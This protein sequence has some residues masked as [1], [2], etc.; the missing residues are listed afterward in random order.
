[1]A[2][3]AKLA[4]FIN[5]EFYLTGAFGEQRQTH[6]HKGVDLSTGEKSPIYSLNAGTCILKA[7]DSGGYGDYVIIKGDDGIGFLYRRLRFSS[8]NSRRSKSRTIPTN[9]I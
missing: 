4:P 1:M 6:I 7:Y 5:K 3:R 8:R 9:W 2:I